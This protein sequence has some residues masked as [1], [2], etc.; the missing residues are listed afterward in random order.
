MIAIIVSVALF[1]AAAGALWGGFIV[2]YG[3][4]QGEKPSWAVFGKH[5][6]IWPYEVY[7]RI[8]GQS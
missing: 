7:Q 4:S 5:A 3:A 8:R 6:A 1:Y 2:L